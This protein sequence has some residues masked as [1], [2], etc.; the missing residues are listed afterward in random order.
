MNLGNIDIHDI[1]SAFNKVKA[2]V[3][4]LTEMEQ[5]VKEAT[6]SD[7]WG[8]SSS[9]MTE[10]AQATYDYQKFNEIMGALYKRFHET[11]KSWRNIYKALTLLE[12]LL[13]NGS[14]RVID[15]ARS[16]N[17][18]L[19]ALD[20]FHHIDEAGKDQGINIRHRAKLIIELIGDSDRLRDERAKAKANKQKY[21]GVGS[22]TGGSKYSGF[23]SSGGSG[24]YGGFGSESNSYGGSS[25][26]GGTSFRDQD[27]SSS[28]GYGYGGGSPTS[29]K[30]S[31]RKDDEFG[32]FQTGGGGGGGFSSSSPP[33]AA[34]APAQPQVNLLAFDEPAAPAPSNNQNAGW[35]A[36]TQAPS[37][38]VQDDFADFQGATI[39]PPPSGGATVKPPGAASAQPNFFGS[40]SPP[41]AAGQSSNGGFGN[42]ASFNTA[43]PPSQPVGGNAN[44]FGSPQ[45]QPQQQQAQQQQNA[46]FANFGAFQ[47]PA[48]SINTSQMQQGSS[49]MMMAPMS[50]QP[51]SA[52][53]AGSQTKNP[54]WNTNLV[55]LDSLGKFNQPRDQTGPSMNALA[56]SQQ[57]RTPTQPGFGA[58]PNTMSASA[59]GQFNRAPSNNNMGMGI[60]GSAGQSSAGGF[61]AFGSPQQ[62]PQQQGQQQQN[63]FAA[64]G[65]FGQNQQQGSN[66]TG[67][68]NH[69]NNLLL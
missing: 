67:S 68:N 55:D 32:D 11:G 38:A 51:Q 24:R 57:T 40:S 5:K 46:S 14:E 45:Q 59:S 63:A 42:F 28:S 29:P 58:F 27:Y 49:G 43:S 36:F 25:G 60:M 47:S 13:K 50:A 39:A 22:D 2:T 31:G 37:S 48:T 9:L 52:T 4:N 6:S 1:K 19:R 10:I 7:P 12:Y 23:G 56:Q 66:N 54:I 61:A 53:A 33:A 64:F 3:M 17:Y 41:P 16:N 35:G 30:S 18:E 21:G 15:S 20:N 8:A 44:F 69:N 65:T 34:S 62:P 26:G